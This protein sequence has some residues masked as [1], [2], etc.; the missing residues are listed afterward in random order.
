MQRGVCVKP[1]YCDTT[2]YMCDQHTLYPTRIIRGGMWKDLGIRALTRFH[3]V[4]R[5][6]LFASWLVCWRVCEHALSF[7]GELL[8]SAVCVHKQGDDN[9]TALSPVF[10]RSAHTRN[11][12]GC[13]VLVYVFCRVRYWL[14][15]LS[16]QSHVF[17]VACA[18]TIYSTHSLTLSIS[19][20]VSHSPLS[21]ITIIIN[22]VRCAYEP[23]TPSKPAHLH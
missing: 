11:L 16:L 5:R 23:Q 18:A 14:K 6:A 10:A 15:A 12:L 1:S 3:I 2:I 7:G 17:T 4:L 22:C 19:H 8:C 21:F 20:S 13:M 9:A